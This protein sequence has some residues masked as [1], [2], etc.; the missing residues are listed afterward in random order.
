MTTKER[1]APWWHARE[2]AVVLLLG[3]AVAACTYT[4]RVALLSDG[5]L[6]GRR[7]DAMPPGPP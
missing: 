2:V 3:V 1:T 6:E 4:S 7:L 5:N